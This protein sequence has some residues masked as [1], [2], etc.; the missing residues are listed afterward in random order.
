MVEAQERGERDRALGRR[1]ADARVPLRRRLRRG[2]WLAAQPYDGAEP[3]NLGTGVGDLDPRARRAD[4]RAHRLRRRDRLGHDEAERAAAPAPRRLSRAGSASGSGAHAAPRRARAHDRVVS[5]LAAR[6]GASGARPT[7]R[8]ARARRGRTISRAPLPE[9][10]AARP[11]GSA[12]RAVGGGGRARANVRTP[13][14][15]LPGG[16][17]LSGTTRWAGCSGHGEIGQTA[18]SATACRGR[19]SPPLRASRA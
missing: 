2:I 13:D 1:L 8:P 3:V 17:P 15:S 6:G 14:G 16:R 12:A 5:E 11:A 19:C 9:S 7:S 4:R 18:A 10:S